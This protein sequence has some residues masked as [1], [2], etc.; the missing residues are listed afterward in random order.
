MRRTRDHRF[1]FMA[2]PLPPTHQILKPMMLHVSASLLAKRFWPS[3]CQL[4]RKHQD[5]LYSVSQFAG[6]REPFQ[7]GGSICPGKKKQVEYISGAQ[8]T[9][10][11]AFKTKIGVAILLFQ[12]QKPGQEDVIQMPSL[13]TEYGKAGINSESI[14]NSLDVFQAGG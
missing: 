10:L 9:L 6:W 3:S 1:Y 14:S 7:H 5:M 11:L 2:P 4:N 12:N 13:N 8:E